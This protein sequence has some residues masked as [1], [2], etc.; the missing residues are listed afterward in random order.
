[1]E[2]QASDPSVAPCPCPH[3]GHDCAINDCTL[4]GASYKDESLL[5]DFVMCTC[6]RWYQLDSGTEEKSD[7]ITKDVGCPYCG[8]TRCDYLIL[9]DPETRDVHCETCGQDYI[10]PKRSPENPA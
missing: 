9:G 1:M 6:G 10:I 4:F 7:T 3:C 8:E 2:N 5:Y